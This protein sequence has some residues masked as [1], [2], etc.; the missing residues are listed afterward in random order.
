[1]ETSVVYQFNSELAE[2]SEKEL[3]NLDG[4]L[5][6]VNPS[7]AAD[8]ASSFVEGFKTGFSTWRSFVEKNL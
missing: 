1:M 5:M 3:I 6:I 4:G 8:F 2:L 7:I